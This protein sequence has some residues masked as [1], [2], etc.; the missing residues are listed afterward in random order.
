MKTFTIQLKASDITHR[1]A[2]HGRLRSEGALRT[3]I[4]RDRSKYTRKTKH[5]G[6][7]E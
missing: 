7:D 3:R 5:K 2:E 6:G 4:V 1:N